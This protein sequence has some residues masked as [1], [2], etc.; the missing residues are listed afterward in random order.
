MK[1][2]L[3]SLNLLLSISL[4]VFLAGCSQ[5]AASIDDVRMPVTAQEK[6]PIRVEKVPVKLTVR[7]ERG[8]LSHDDASA[9]QQFA[10]AARSQSSSDISVSYPSHSPKARTAA[11]Q[12]VRI[13]SREGVG[14][15]SIR[16]M[17]YSGKS[18]VVSLTYFRK[19]A[20]TEPCGD[21]SRNIANDS[22]NV[23]Y[24]NLGC[25]AQNNL[26]AMVANPEDIEKPRAMTD[27]PAA[28]QMPTMKSYET[29]EWSKT[30]APLPTATM[31]SG[32]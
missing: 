14:R 13:L 15:E 25:T 10:R 20:V 19:A 22:K 6:F 12:A 7:P 30:P 18:D 24:Q 8:G 3:P 29:G 11:D 32:S 28:G 27:A 1:N 21:W 4:S 17:S 9:L 2:V 31:D 5:D 23:S 16:I 26:A